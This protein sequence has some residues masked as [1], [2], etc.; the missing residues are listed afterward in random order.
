MELSNVRANRRSLIR[1]ASTD[2]LEVLLS[3]YQLCL[4][5]GH[6]PGKDHGLSR[7]L[8][9]NAGFY[10][11]ALALVSNLTRTRSLA[12]QV[13]ISSLPSLLFD[14][15]SDRGIYFPLFGPAD[16]GALQNAR[17]PL[18]CVR[19]IDHAALEH[20]RIGKHKNDLRKLSK[21]G[22]EI[23]LFWSGRCG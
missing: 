20:G 23:F 12:L 6:V 3:L 21:N 22:H 16:D 7:L 18:A 1:N 9:H 4:A 10:G 5:N 13:K 15:Y 2:E 14:L 11:L 8:A 19:G 17:R